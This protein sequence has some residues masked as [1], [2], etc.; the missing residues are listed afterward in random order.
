M[1]AAAAVDEEVDGEVDEVYELEQFLPSELAARRLHTA[2]DQVLDH[3]LD[4]PNN[5]TPLTL[6]FRDSRKLF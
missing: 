2:A 6:H 1:P 3:R 4:Q 5:A